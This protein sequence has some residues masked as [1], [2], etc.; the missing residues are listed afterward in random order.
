MDDAF[1]AYGCAINAVEMFEA[2]DVENFVYCILMYGCTYA[3]QT[4]QIRTVVAF[5]LVI[6]SW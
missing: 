4:L 6:V 5:F 3:Y 1:T 2:P